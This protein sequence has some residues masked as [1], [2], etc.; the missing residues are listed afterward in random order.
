MKVWRGF[1]GNV[2]SQVKRNS[3]LGAQKVSNKIASP[4][5][6]NELEFEIRIGD[7]SKQWDEAAFPARL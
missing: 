1:L 5:G 2:S 3:S 6:S 7:P 4:V